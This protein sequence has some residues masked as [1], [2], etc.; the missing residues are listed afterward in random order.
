MVAGHLQEKKGFFYMVLSYPDITGKRKTKWFP[1]GL[2]VKGNKKRAEKMLMQTRQTFEPECTP[3]QDDMMFSDFLLQWLEIAKPTIALTTYA[4]YAGMAKSI[5]IPY[6]K[7][8]NTTLAG[9]KAI[10]IQ[11]FYM[12]QLKRVK[13]SSVIH[14]HA[15]IHR[16][17]KYAVKIDLIS[18]NPAD[19]VERPKADKFI[20]SF[21]DSDEMQALFEAAKDTLLEIP[22]FLG[23]FYGLRRSE[24]LGLKWDAIDFQNGTIT[25]RHTVTSCTIDGKHVQVAKDTTKTKSSMR[26]LPLVPVFKEKLLK[27]K[28]QQAEYR[29]VCGKCYDNR[30]LEYIC[31]DEMGTLIS[32]H[33]LT[34]AFPKLL[35]KN[36]LRRIR[37]HDLRHSCASLL[38]A[39]GVPM[40]QIQEWLGHSD[41]STTAN[42]Y[43]H[44]DY[45]SKLSSAD[46][47]AK[48]LSGA[49]EVIS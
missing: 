11:T 16:A 24:A 37:Y 48:G 20:G 22:I 2:P 44:L 49:L 1:T 36:E 31:V 27:V 32:P 41:F 38:L 5:I 28:E 47:M 46:A 14:Y 34:A 35:D 30:Y 18:V 10:D 43:A 8:R 40:K 17:L 9:L 21:Y 29:R 45:N 39:N 12:Q 23:A 42:V 19:K 26:T 13:A 25:I 15:V 7:E 4:S 33:Y 6:F 3:V